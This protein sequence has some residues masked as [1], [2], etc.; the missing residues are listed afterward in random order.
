M[1]MLGQAVRVRLAPRD[2]GVTALDL[3]HGPQ[4]AAIT[5]RHGRRRALYAARRRHAVH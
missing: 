3:P 5:P 1:V 2:D 4:L